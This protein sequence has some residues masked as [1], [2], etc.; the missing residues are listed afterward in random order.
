L[1][2][3]TTASA[4]RFF[5]VVRTADRP[6]LEPKAGDAATLVVND[7]AILIAGLPGFLEPPGMFHRAVEVQ[8]GVAPCEMKLI[9]AQLPERV[10]PRIQFRNLINGVTSHA[11]DLADGRADLKLKR[12]IGSVFHIFSGRLVRHEPPSSQCRRC[13]I[14]ARMPNIGPIHTFDFLP[15][16]PQPIFARLTP[17]LLQR[18]VFNLRIPFRFS[19]RQP[20]PLP[21]LPRACKI[22]ATSA[23]LSGVCSPRASQRVL[24][25]RAEYQRGSAQRSCVQRSRYLD[26]GIS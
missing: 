25:D 7:D 1:A 10:L 14:A 24:L 21:S 18:N 15:P 3:V 11:I 6:R 20:S 8:N 22:M 5:R 12:R 13:T 23:S 17:N 4:P 26:P 9:G 2:I 19:S 16:Q